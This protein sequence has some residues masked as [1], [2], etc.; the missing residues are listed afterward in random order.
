MIRRFLKINN[1][2]KRNFSNDRNLPS[3]KYIDSSLNNKKI[4]IKSERKEDE[5]NIKK[6]NNSIKKRKSSDNDLLHLLPKGKK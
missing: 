6:E 4:G 2:I 5:I 1:I 3:V